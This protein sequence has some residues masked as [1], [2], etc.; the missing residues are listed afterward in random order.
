MIQISDLCFGYNLKKDLFSNLNLDIHPGQIH[1]LLGLNG[2]GKSS[3]LHLIQGLRFCDT[4]SISVFGQ[5]PQSRS[6]PLLRESFLLA[7]EIYAPNMSMKKFVDRFAPFYPKF[8]LESFLKFLNEFELA[9][10]SHLAKLSMGQ[11]KKALIAFGLATNTNLLM[12]DEPTNGLD[13]PSKKQFRKILAHI[14]NEN[15]IYIISTHQIRDLHSLIDNV[16]VI[17]DGKIIFNHTINDICK[18]LHFSLAPQES[19]HSNIIYQERVPGG[20]LKIK[21][22]NGRTS[23]EPDL[24]VLF[25]AIMTVNDSI[26]HAFQQHSNL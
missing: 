8:S 10:N 13:I 24:E 1:G 18:N 17:N 9:H 4:G 22:A 23:F 5:N 26:K 21:N 2:A 12:M 16:I 20:Y 25:N 14:I 3:L 6:V 11:K 7:E 19:N 15:R